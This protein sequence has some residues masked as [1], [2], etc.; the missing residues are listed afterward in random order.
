MNAYNIC[1][2]GI[3]AIKSGNHTKKQ[4][5]KIMNK[6]SKKDCSVYIKSLKCNSCKINLKNRIKG[7]QLKN[8]PYK[9]TNKRER[10][11]LNKKNRCNKCKNNNTKKCNLKKYILYSGA[12]LG[13]CEQ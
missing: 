12:K 5:L 11:L 9:M 13:I 4:F 8:K 3:G 6:T 1:Y 2:T 10:K 7:L